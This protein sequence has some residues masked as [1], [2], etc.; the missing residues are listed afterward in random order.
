MA[1]GR[2]GLDVAINYKQGE[3]RASLKAAAPTGIDVYFEMPAANI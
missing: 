2:A 1:E 3:L